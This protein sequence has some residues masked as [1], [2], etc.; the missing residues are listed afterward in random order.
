MKTTE[1]FLFLL[2]CLLYFKVG[3][4]IIHIIIHNYNT[5][6]QLTYRQILG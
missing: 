2:Y 5:N 4:I 3:Y 6:N 1:I